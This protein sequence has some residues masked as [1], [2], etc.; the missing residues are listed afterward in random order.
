MARKSG[1][2]EGIEGNKRETPMF[3]L[4]TSEADE[5]QEQT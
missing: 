5:A 1:K 3:L 2:Q 4:Q